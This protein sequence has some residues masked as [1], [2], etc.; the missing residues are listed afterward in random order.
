MPGGGD[1]VIVALLFVGRL[2]QLERLVGG[3]M[4]L[5]RAR[6]GDS[7]PLKPL[8]PERIDEVHVVR[9]LQRGH[10]DP[11]RGRGREADAGGRLRGRVDADHADTDQAHR[12]RD[13]HVEVGLGVD[14]G[15]GLDVGRELRGQ[16]RVHLVDRVAVGDRLGV[17]LGV[18]DED[19]LERLEVALVGQVEQVGCGAA[20][21]DHRALQACPAEDVA[22]V[23]H[24]A[25]G[26]A[27]GR[28][29]DGA[30]V[31]VEVEGLEDCGLVRHL[32]AEGELGGLVRHLP[33]GGVDAH[34]LAILRLDH[35][36]RVWDRGVRHEALTPAELEDGAPAVG[37]LVHLLERLNAL[38]RVLAEGRVAEELVQRVDQ[39]LVL[40]HEV[41]HLQ[42]LRGVQRR[43]NELAGVVHRGEGERRA[44]A[45]DGHLVVEGDLAGEEGVPLTALDRVHAVD[46]ERRQDR[47]G[48]LGLVEALD[49]PK[50]CRDVACVG[51]ELLAQRRVEAQQVGLRVVPAD[52]ERAEAGGVGA[53]VQ[54]DEHVDLLELVER[55][56]DRHV[57]LLALD[58]V[59]QPLDAQV[60]GG[61][62][63]LKLPDD[64]AAGK[65]LLALKLR[66]GEARAEG[67]E[68]VLALLHLADLVAG[69]LKRL[70]ELLKLTLKLVVAVAALAGLPRL[71]APQVHEL[72]RSGE[73][74]KVAAARE[75]DD[76][77]LRPVLLLAVDLRQ[78]EE[79]GD[80]DRV[81]GSRREG[82]DD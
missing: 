64:D 2:R 65:L 8:K 61:V 44:P 50:L 6:V 11:G 10:R 14:D 36:H 21:D 33:D 49:E 34:H 52:L 16:Q 59:L 3:V 31:G 9:D 68:G 77:A 71:A 81:L 80:G 46:E 40:A 66:R 37:Q 74:L 26:P 75:E 54:P 69:A 22:R 43:V 58:V 20:E 60:G 62:I 17:V 42:P 41:V 35:D 15:A 82:R 1:S 29:D 56:P 23:F 55:L 24:V 67:A 27:V 78:L 32:T 63:K 13:L 76:A 70:V 25:V 30:A 5:N 79:G 19:L 12:H 18:V 53:Q 57:V 47:S 72:A 4:Q 51:G 7:M 38:E 28:V 73:R 45:A 48:V 39:H